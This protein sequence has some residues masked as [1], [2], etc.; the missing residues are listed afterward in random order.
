MQSFNY[1]NL[2]DEG[3]FIFTPTIPSDQISG[4]RLKLFIPSVPREEEAMNLHD[5]SL[6]E[7]KSLGFHGRDSVY[8]EDLKKYADF[9][10][11]FVN[12]KAYPN[13]EFQYYKHPHAQE[14]GV[15]TY[16]PTADFK[17]GKNVLE[18]RKEYFSKEKVQKIVAIPFYF[19]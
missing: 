9:N 6:R 16:I 7:R 15:L 4:D 11:V 10:K 12:N 17:K 1:D 18:I 2:R 19:E 14:S 3:Q 8:I 5:L 13:L